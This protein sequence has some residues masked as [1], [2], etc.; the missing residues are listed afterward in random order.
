MR[1]TFFIS[2]L[3]K[4]KG[5]L[6]LGTISL[7]LT[8]EVMESIPTFFERKMEF[9]FSYFIFTNSMYAFRGNSI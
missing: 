4:L 8:V 1:M 3:Y 2:L 9:L 5:G 6:P 7:G